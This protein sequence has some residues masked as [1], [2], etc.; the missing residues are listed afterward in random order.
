MGGEGEMYDVLDPHGIE[1]MSDVEL[2]DMAE[3]DGIEDII[4]MDGEGD[5]ANREEVIVALKNVWVSS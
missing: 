3:K 5:L 1:K 2:I 4:V